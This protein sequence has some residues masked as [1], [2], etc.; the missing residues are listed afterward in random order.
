MALVIED[1]TGKPDADSWA[2][3]ADTTAYWTLRK[4]QG[5]ID[6]D[7]ETREAKL[8]E[9]ADY[10]MIAYRWPG[11][12]AVVGQRLPWPRVGVPSGKGYYPSD[13]IPS[14]VINAQMVLAVEA[15]TKPLLKKAAP[16][17]VVIEET[18]QVSGVGS[19]TFKYATA[20]V[21]QLSGLPRFFTVDNIL[22]GIATEAVSSS[23]VHQVPLTRG[24]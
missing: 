12:P 19:K 24:L 10:L 7:A 22:A 2:T 6:A 9:A 18:K 4:E 14:Q 8:R 23:G 15:L 1:G 17:R 21:D 13:G 11:Q 5:W 20:A 3:E 16:D